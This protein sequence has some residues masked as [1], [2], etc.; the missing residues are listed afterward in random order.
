MSYNIGQ[1]LFLCITANKK[2]VTIAIVKP[3]AVGA[4]NVD[5]IIKDVSCIYTCLHP[6]QVRSL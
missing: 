4:G 3:D 5:R 2:K 6:S 1:L